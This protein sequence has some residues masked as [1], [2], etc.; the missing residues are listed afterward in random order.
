MSLYKIEII[1][2]F[3]QNLEML[4]DT[5][6]RDAKSVLEFTDTHPFLLKEFDNFDPI[7]I[8]QRLHNLDKWFHCSFF[9]IP[10]LEYSR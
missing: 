9:Y 6:L 8:G 5:W 3:F 4:G 7:W 10:S 1:P 2:S